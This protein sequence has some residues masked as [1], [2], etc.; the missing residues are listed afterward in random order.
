VRPVLFE[1]HGWIETNVYSRD[2]LNAGSVIEGPAI[3]EEQSSSTVIEPGQQLVVDEY[4]NLIIDTG[5]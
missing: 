2:I 1:E 5:V 3:V 4:G